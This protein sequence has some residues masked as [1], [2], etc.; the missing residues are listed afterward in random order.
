[1]DIAITGLTLWKIGRGGAMYSPKTQRALRRLRNLTIEAAVPPTIGVILNI[2]SCRTMDDRN[3]VS[4]FFAVTTPML[5]VL[6]MMFTLNS[7]VKNS[8]TFNASSRKDEEMLSTGFQFAKSHVS[9]QTSEQ[10]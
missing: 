8:Q 2:A 10:A 1:T 9:D 3:S 4:R 6:S 5:Y 7:R